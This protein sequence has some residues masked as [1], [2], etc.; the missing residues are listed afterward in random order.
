MGTMW[1]EPTKISEDLLAKADME[2]KKIVGK[3]LEKAVEVLRKNKGKLKL[4]AEEL[5]KKE[6]LESEDFDELMKK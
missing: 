3:G 2:V 4:V 5:L 6:T 1:Y